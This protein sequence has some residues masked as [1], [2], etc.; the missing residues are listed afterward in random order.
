MFGDGDSKG[1]TNME[2]IDNKKNEEMNTKTER[3]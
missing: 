1:E 2:K 3:K